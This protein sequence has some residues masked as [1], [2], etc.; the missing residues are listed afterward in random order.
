MSDALLTG[1]ATGPDR[2]TI[3]DRVRASAV[4]YFGTS[5]VVVA[6]R[7]GRIS[8][9]GFVADYEAKVFHDIDSRGYGPSVCRGCSKQSWPHNPLNVAKEWA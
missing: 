7:S 9:D 6:L 8:D 4:T 2:A 5:C 1:T 3:Q